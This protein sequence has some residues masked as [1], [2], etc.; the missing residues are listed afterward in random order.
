M[1]LLH[2]VSS[3]VTSLELDQEFK[4]GLIRALL[5]TLHHLL[6]VVLEDVRTS[7]PRFVAE[8]PI[9]FL[10]NDDAAC[11]R[12]SAPEIHAPEER[13]VLPPGKSTW[14]LDA[15]LF[16]ELHGVNVRKPF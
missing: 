5:K 10:A 2:T 4:C 7:A 13:S 1:E 14:E 11:T 16:E 8:P 3:R 12:I 15:Q 6:P 9:S